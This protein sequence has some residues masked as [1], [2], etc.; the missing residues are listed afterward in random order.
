MF[1]GEKGL[2]RARLTVFDVGRGR[3]PSAWP[4]MAAGAEMAGGSWH[5]VAGYLAV[6]YLI[7]LLV[8]ARMLH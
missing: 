5:L 4:G 1:R 3:G 2:L 7:S 6:G 8:A